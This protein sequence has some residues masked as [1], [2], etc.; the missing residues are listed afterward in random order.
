MNIYIASDHSGVKEKE[1]ITEYLKNF[2]D[3]IINDLGPSE[4]DGSID[5]PFYAFKLAHLI[6]NK[7][8]ECYGILICGT[9]I[10]MDIVANKFKCIRAAR[11]LDNEDAKLSRQH[12][13]ANVLCLS[14]RKGINSKYSKDI[15]TTFIKTE[16]SDEERH[17]RRVDMM[18]I[19]D[20]SI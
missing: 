4:E 3:V 5:Y 12:N 9:G 14:S 6:Q 15:V 16:F 2:N 1:I 17:N 8:E 11:C 7:E 13:N 18:Y 19:L 10:G 20:Y